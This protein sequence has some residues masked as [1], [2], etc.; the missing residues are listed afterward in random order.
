MSWV[1]S[2]M[3][4][5]RL[6]IPFFSLA[7]PGP[8]IV[9]CMV[10]SSLASCFSLVALNAGRLFDSFPCSSNTFPPI[11]LA[12]DLVSIALGL[13]SNCFRSHEFN[14]NVSCSPFYFLPGFFALGSQRCDNAGDS[15]H[16]DNI[17]GV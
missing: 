5:N 13:L 6:C 3:P 17:P 14:M 8:C 4:G 12:S 11:Y 9:F 1:F 7:F 10:A 2:C 16:P 15:S